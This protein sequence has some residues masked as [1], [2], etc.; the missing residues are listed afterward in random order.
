LTR[1]RP[2]REFGFPGAAG[3]RRLTGDHLAL[4]QAIRRGDPHLTFHHSDLGREMID[5]NIDHPCRQLQ[6]ERSRD[7]P[8]RFRLCLGDAVAQPAGALL[9]RL[10]PIA[11]GE[12]EAAVGADAEVTAWRIDNQPAAAAGSDFA[13]AGE[14]LTGHR[15]HPDRACGRRVA[16]LAGPLDDAPAGRS[17]RGGRLG[18][19][20]RA[21]AQR[22]EQSQRSEPLAGG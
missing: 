16:R 14:S 19:R 9:Q 12:H 11:V 4:A 13:A 20:G 7:D 21:G 3:T 8:E 6:L 22:S 10:L 15:R 5:I 18:G 1:C 2:D 17:R